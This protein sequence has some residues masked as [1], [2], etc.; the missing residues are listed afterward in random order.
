MKKFFCI[1]ILG[2][3]LLSGCALVE[4]SGEMTRATGK[5]MTDYSKKHTGLIAKGAGVGGRINER[6]GESVT[7][8]GKK[9]EGSPDESKASQ[10]VAANKEVLAAAR[11]AVKDDT[12]VMIRVQKRLLALGYDIGK[13]DGKMGPKTKLA[14]R[15]YQKKNGLKMT[16]TLDQPTLASLEVQE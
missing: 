15:D 12:A 11:G 6:V 8:I 14:L 10:F 5:V 1:F 16:Q 4:M 13:P 9:G 3:S 2:S 7:N